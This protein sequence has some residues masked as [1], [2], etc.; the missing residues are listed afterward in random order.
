MT[1]FWNAKTTYWQSSEVTTTAKFGYSYPEFNGLDLGNPEAV[2]REITKK[3]NQM[4]GDF[5]MF[6]FASRQSSTALSINSTPSAPGSSDGSYLDWTARVHVKKYEIGGSFAVLLFIG[7]V[8]ENPSEWD[9]SPSFAGAHYGFVNSAVENCDN[10]IGQQEAGAV[11]EGFVHLN[12]TLMR[13]LPGGSFD[14][15]VVEPVLKEKLNWRVRKVSS[16]QF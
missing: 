1:P 5:S 10:C 12:R 11:L 7:D 4:Y 9:A 6:S 14:E 13:V 3:I 8:P 15:D 2:R 16:S